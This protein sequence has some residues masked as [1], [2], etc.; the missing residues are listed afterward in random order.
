MQILIS[1]E[2]LSRA[3]RQFEAPV[4]LDFT[5]TDVTISQEIEGNTQGITV[6][7]VRRSDDGPLFPRIVLFDE[8]K[9]AVERVLMTAE[10]VWLKTALADAWF[11]KFRGRI[12]VHVPVWCFM[13]KSQSP[14]L[15]RSGKPVNVE[16]ELDEDDP[17]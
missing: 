9:Q 15:V 3:L 1:A 17:Q 7:A 5:K 6:T 10:Q 16:K 4:T 11:V 8:D 12:G 2:S 14:V 13:G